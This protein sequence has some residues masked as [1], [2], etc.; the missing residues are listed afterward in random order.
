MDARANLRLA[1][2]AARVSLSLLPLSLGT[3]GADAG[4]PLGEGCS[5]DV[6]VNGD[7]APLAAE[8]RKQ[9]RKE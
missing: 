4:V 7:A 6:A 8:Q 9:R 5:L 3:L 2:G 1:A